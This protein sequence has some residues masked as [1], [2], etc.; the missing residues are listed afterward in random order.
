M[1]TLILDIETSYFIA[2]TFSL[3]PK[4]INHNNILK[5]WHVISGAWKWLGENQIFSISTY[6]RND[7]K[8]IS[9]LRKAIIKADEIVYHNGRKFDYKKMNTRVIGNQL[10]P[11][12]KPKEI[13]TLIQARKH[14]AF[15]SNRLDYIG[16][17]L[18]VG[19]KMETSHG[20]WLK[21]LDGDK[22]AI[23]EM[24]KYNKQD[25]QLLEDV[26][27]VMKPYID[28]GVNK[29]I[30][31]Q[32][33]DKCPRCE[34]SNLQKRGWTYTKTCRYQRYQCTNCGSWSQSGNRQKNIVTPFR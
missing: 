5:D 1:G 4:S 3:W 11:M 28:Y 24:E 20:L 30:N 16:A 2:A 8:V 32:L 25:V 26:Y 27:L 33:G 14:F 6:T 7:K 15:T 12:P 9:E 17:Y 29:N 13:D 19:R 31:K 10:P 23:D 34:S 21:A 22:Q 18:G